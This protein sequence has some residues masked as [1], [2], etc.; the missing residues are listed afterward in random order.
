[1]QRTLTLLAGLL[2]I[3]G[4]SAAT[5]H[6]SGDLMTSDHPL[7][8]AKMAGEA[9]VEELAANDRDEIEAKVN[10]ADKR[11]KEADKLA[12][13]GK[14]AE[15]EETANAYAQEMQE[16]NDLGSH[17]SDLAQ[18]QEIDQLIAEATQHHADVLSRV[19]EKLPEQARQNVEGALNESI[20]G[21]ENAVNAMEQRGQDTSGIGNMSDKIPKDVASQAGIDLSSIG[22]ESTGP[23]GAGGP[24]S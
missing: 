17:V 4:L 6:N 5:M 22:P 10:H 21:Y 1:M 19:H 9:G 13:E 16:V 18:K 12:E 20:R 23:N 15:A 3:T 8:E 11:A 14:T 24:P 2:L 7:Y